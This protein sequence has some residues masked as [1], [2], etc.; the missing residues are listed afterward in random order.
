MKGLGLIIHREL[1]LA[2]RQTG[3][4]VVIVLFF[5][6]AAVL[7]PFGIGPEPNIL[8]RMAPGTVWVTALLAAMLSFERLFAPDYDDGS[9]EQLSLA[10]IPLEV[11][12]LGK[13]IAHWLTTGVPLLI[14]A[15]VIAVMFG[16]PEQGY[17]ALIASM[18]LGTPVL[19]LIGTVGA[20]LTLG[21][22]RGGVLLALLV[23][24]LVIPV[25]IFGT[26]AIDAAIGGF[27]IGAHL[28]LLGGMLLAALVLCPWAAAAALRQAL[29]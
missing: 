15:P 21:A 11:I 18:A 5:V 4:S 10:P 24:P 29:E 1:S 22:R 27:A 26:A 19:S 14:A 9:L 13:A 17:G 20:A 28:S 25:L 3:D 2:L 16:M 8:A 7:F 6:L 12:V 23:L